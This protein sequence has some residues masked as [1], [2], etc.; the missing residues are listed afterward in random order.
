MEAIAAISSIAGILS[1]LCQA[2]EN[3]TKLRD[4]LSEASSA[5]ETAGQLLNDIDSLLQ[6]LD[7][8]NGLVKLLPLEFQ[9]SNIVSLQL[10]IEAYT[11]DVFDWFKV[12][13]D[14]RPAQ[15]GAK[16]WFKKLWIATNIKSIKEIRVELDRHKENISLDLTILGR[17]ARLFAVSPL[18]F[19]T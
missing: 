17:Y 4:F 1:L 8:V 10:R 12:A 13:K 5:S 11:R 18:H 7:A 16:A 15:N 6:T 19:L 3:T 14:I 9:N 2:I